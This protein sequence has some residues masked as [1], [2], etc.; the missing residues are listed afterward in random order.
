MQSFKKVL[1][2]I[3]CF[4]IG[5]ILLYTGID[6]F[7]NH[8]LPLII[9]GEKVTGEIHNLEYVRSGRNSAILYTVTLKFT[10]LDGKD[11]SDVELISGVA[12]EGKKVTVTYDP[13]NPTNH[14]V[15]DFNLLGVLVI[16]LLGLVFIF[17]GIMMIKGRANLVGR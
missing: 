11:V 14:N 10:T 4:L 3:L 6:S 8:D 16:P 7:L 5:G 9:R 12:Y 15:D 2:T 1:I 17:F 13:K